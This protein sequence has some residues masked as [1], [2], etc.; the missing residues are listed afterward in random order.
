[1][2]AQQLID[3]ILIAALTVNTLS[4]WRQGKRE[5]DLARRTDDLEKVIW[6]SRRAS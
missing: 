3:T 6:P 2:T 1:M 4:N 5:R